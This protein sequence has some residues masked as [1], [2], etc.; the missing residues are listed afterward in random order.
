MNGKRRLRGRR[1]ADAWAR[2]LVIGAVV[3]AGVSCLKLPEPEGR[4]TG[5][6][7]PAV[8][9]PPRPDLTV[10]RIPERHPDGAFTVEGFL[11]H[12]KEIYA[13]EPGHRTATVRGY[14]REV[15]R[16]PEGSRLCPTVPHLV[17]VDSLTTPRGRLFVVSDPPEAV[18]EG[19]PAESQQTLQGE[20]ALWSPD[21][22]LVDLRGLLVIRVPGGET[23]PDPSAQAPRPEGTAP[24]RARAATA[25]PPS[26]PR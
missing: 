2:P 15:V 7:K 22:R 5:A 14:V 10:Q 20:V 25:T 13:N 8:T 12:A 1:P 26:N 16:C 6:K 23:A 18:L 19:F 17:L 24:P 11:R 9:L 21:G 3:L 4:K